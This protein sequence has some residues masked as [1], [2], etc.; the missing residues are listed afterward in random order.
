MAAGEPTGA[1]N[2]LSDTNLG[3]RT[4]TPGNYSYS[5]AA[6]LTGPL[7]LDAQ[8]NPNARFVF[9]IGSQLTTASASSVLLI[10]GASPCNVY[11]RSAP[12]PSSAP[13]PSSRAT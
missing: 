1:G 8:G 10:N 5:S 9:K 6:L 12:R 3:N 13:P 2:D 7:V 11:W 4:L